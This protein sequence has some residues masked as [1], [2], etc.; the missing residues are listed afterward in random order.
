M[1]KS[2][3]NILIKII[4]V[5]YFFTFIIIISFIM[6]KFNKVSR[7]TS[8]ITENCGLRAICDSHVGAVKFCP[9]FFKQRYPKISI[10]G[11]G[12]DWFTLVLI[13]RNIIVN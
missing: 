7:S 3:F 1:I 4:D 11:V 9:C 8:K 6:K 10:P 13:A 5:W 12:K 2:I